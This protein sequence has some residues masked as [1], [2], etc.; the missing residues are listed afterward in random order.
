M[1]KKKIIALLCAVFLCFNFAGCSKTNEKPKDNSGEITTPEEKEETTAFKDFSTEISKDK[2][3]ESLKVLAPKDDARITGTE[4]EKEAGDYIASEFE[5]YGL[6]L[7]NQDFPVISYECTSAALKIV[8]DN[9][10][11]MECK[12]LSFSKS[13]TEEGVTGEL[14]DGGYGTN[15]ELSKLGDIKG[16]IVLAKRGK[17][18]FGGIAFLAS[19]MN[20][21]GV[22]IFDES[23]DEILNG[24]LGE[25]SAVPA[26]AVTKK[27]GQELAAKLKNGTSINVNM[28]VIGDFT[29]GTSR[30]IVGLKKSKDPDA[31]T[32]IVGAHYDCVDTP[33]ANDNASGITAVM[34]AA[35]VLS[36]KDL[37]CNVLFIAFGSEETG[38]NGSIYYAY[39]MT[40]EDVANTVAMINADMVG[41]GDMLTIY[42][43]TGDDLRLS[44]LAVSCAK[45]M[46]YTYITEIMGRS[47]HVPFDEAGIPVAFFA[48]AP[49]TNYHTDE[50]TID[51]IDGDNMLRACNIITS[52][53]YKVACDP[54]S[55]NK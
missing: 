29:K 23:T 41:V 19:E 52:L 27:D 30:N 7:K 5:E 6:E 13:T 4:G 35:K 15:E 17:N 12:A 21:A 2:M 40:K 54:E 47:D 14:V 55:L 18:A 42:T 39:S 10:S 43:E 26:I 3:M 33:G 32:V 44:D 37:K 34:E 22:I 48:Y 49:D 51:K 50:D 46:K 38:L 8:S 16:K 45:E 36:D 9:N 24:T 53:C 20:A 31:K 25:E 28:K 1:V 11:D